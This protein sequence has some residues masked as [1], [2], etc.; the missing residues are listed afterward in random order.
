MIGI[1]TNDV[2]III[3]KWLEVISADMRLFPIVQVV[4]AVSLFEVFVN[5]IICLLIYYFFC[6]HSTLL[7][8]EATQDGA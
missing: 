4:P 2:D 6:S 7:E 3:N 8:F 5:F 1:R